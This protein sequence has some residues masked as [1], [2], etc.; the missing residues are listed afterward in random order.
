[1]PCIVSSI[2][3]DVLKFQDD[4]KRFGAGL[5]HASLRTANELIKAA[6]LIVGFGDK[7]IPAIKDMRGLKLGFLLTVSPEIRDTCRVRVAS[8]DQSFTREQCEQIR[9]SYGTDG[10]I[11]FWA[12]IK[13]L[14][15]CVDLFSENLSADNGVRTSARNECARVFLDAVFAEDTDRVFGTEGS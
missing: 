14:G 10:Q 4:D 13:R 11:G 15:Q 12:E 1:L 5:P 3:R 7:K 8:E 2:G 6:A 9:D